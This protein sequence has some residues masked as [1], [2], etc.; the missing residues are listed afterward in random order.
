MYIMCN[1]R[2]GASATNRCFN[3][4]R[5]NKKSR[6][7]NILEFDFVFYDYCMNS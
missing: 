7:L 5:F 4:I 1:K 2:E 3:S 6:F